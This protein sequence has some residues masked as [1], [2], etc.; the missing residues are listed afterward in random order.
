M[1]LSTAFEMLL[2]DSYGAVTATLNRRARLVLTGTSGVKNMV[3]AV[4]KTYNARSSVVHTGS[5]MDVDLALARKA[6]ALCFVEL[7]ERLPHL[8][9]KS[10]TP[11][12]DLT[13]HYSPP[14]H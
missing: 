2:T 11:I 5:D 14:A 4:V 7:V 1:A 6:F 13:D 3:C 12:A 10:A 9:V 8:S